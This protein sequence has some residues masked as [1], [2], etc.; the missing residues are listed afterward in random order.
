MK[1]ACFIAGET[2]RLRGHGSK[3]LM[4]EEG[5]DG[6]H[7]YEL[8]KGKSFPDRTRWG[9]GRAL[10]KERNR[11]R[12]GGGWKRFITE[13]KKNQGMVVAIEK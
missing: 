11:P 6:S 10:E 5:G 1:R 9:R 7:L 8:L 2:F 4:R 13:G 12:W 3:M